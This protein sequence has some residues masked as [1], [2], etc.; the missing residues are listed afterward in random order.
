MRFAPESDDPENAGLAQAREAL[1]PV[2]VKHPG[3]S[4]SDL[5]I[6]AAYCA[7]EHTGGPRIDFDFM[8]RPILNF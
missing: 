6:L 4:Y 3:I 8:F 1:E 2:K 5:W 7:I